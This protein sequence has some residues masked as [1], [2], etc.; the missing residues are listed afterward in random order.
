[1][2]KV[3]D[4]VISI[5]IF[6]QKFVLIKGMLQSPRLKDDVKTI[7]IDLSLSNNALFEHKCIQN[8]N[9]LY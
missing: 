6:E 2:T 7:G 1:M 8:I 3:I 4:Y 5:N 9:K